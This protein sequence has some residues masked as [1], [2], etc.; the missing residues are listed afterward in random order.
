M[1]EQGLARF[2]P[3]DQ[4]RRPVAHGLHPTIE[5]VVV[6]VVAIE[7]VGFGEGPP[8][9]LDQLG[10]LLRRQFRSGREQLPEALRR[11]AMICALA[12]DLS[13]GGDSAGYEDVVRLLMTAHRLRAGPVA[14]K[15]RVTER[16]APRGR[17]G[18]LVDAVD[19]GAGGRGLQGRAARARLLRLAAGGEARAVDAGGAGAVEVA[20]A[21]AGA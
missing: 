21:R 18:E 15:P 8:E 9:L 12:V 17:L 10:A 2:F 5:P 20:R 13:S 14:R 1:R 19:L 16:S 4:R 11:H 6:Q 7:V 3:R